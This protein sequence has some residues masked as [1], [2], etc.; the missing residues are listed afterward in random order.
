MA[1]TKAGVWQ[2]TARSEA[3]GRASH[4]APNGMNDGVA[5][6][7]E[8]AV[9]ESAEGEIR[10]DVRLDRETVWLTR[11]QMAQ[12]FETTPENVLTHLRNVFASGELEADATT[13]EFLVV[14]TEGR[15]RVRLSLK[16]YNLDAII[17]VG[18]RVNSRR[19]VRFRQ[20]PP[21]R[22]ITTLCAA[23]P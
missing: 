17:S 21:G 2:R 23:R 22:C 9:Y 4:G 18:Y 1:V 6:G 3:D 12:V 13:K 20:R 14:R 10:V 7:G 8:V 16:H 5:P 11:R 19:G 15:R